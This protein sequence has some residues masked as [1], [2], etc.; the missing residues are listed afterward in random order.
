MGFVYL[1]VTAK[2]SVKRRT[3]KCITNKLSLTSNSHILKV[4]TSTVEYQLNV[5]KR[6]R[7]SGSALLLKVQLA[8]SRSESADKQSAKI[9]T[10]LHWHH[11]LRFLRPH[12]ITAPELGSPQFSIKKNRKGLERWVQVSLWH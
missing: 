5:T 8:H 10:P 3:K 1:T 6:P 9:S 4:K 11:L 7:L 2:W 12:C